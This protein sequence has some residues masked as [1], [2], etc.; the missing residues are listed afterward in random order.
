MEDFKIN[1]TS[2]NL[3]YGEGTFQVTD[4]KRD[5]RPRERT[6]EQGEDDVVLSGDAEDTEAI[7][8][9]YVPSR[10]NEPEG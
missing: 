1:P 4:R 8:D 5:R 10:P 3:P 2:A 9:Y 7:E 6:P